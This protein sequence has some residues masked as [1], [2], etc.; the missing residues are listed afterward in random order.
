MIRDDNFFT[1]VT[2]INAISVSIKRLIEFFLSFFN[3]F[4]IFLPA[5]PFP[6][7]FTSPAVIPTTLFNSHFLAWAESFTGSSSRKLPD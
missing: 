1:G 7:R 5:L 4:T 2:T 3:R 6:L